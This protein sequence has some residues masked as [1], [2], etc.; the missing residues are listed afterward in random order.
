MFRFEISIG[1][2]A[3][4]HFAVAVGIFAFGFSQGVLAAD[5]PVKAPVKMLSPAYNWTG[6]YIGAH[7]G[8]AWGS[9]RWIDDPIFGGTNLGSHS[10]TGGFGGGQIGYN[11]QTGQWVFGVEASA[12]GADLKGSHLDPQA[13]DIHTRVDAFGTITGRVGY[14]WDNVLL[15]AKG[16]GAWESVKYDDFTGLGLPLNGANSSGR[17][18]WTW[19][20]GVEY[21]FMPNWSLF[22]EYNGFEFP[23]EFLSFS[24]GVAPPYG[25]TIRDR[26]GMVKAGINFRIWPR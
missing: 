1:G 20:G 8:Y 24:G 13:S 18:G 2:L 10:I 3:M 14:A 15:Y 19:G 11:W 5:M 9:S 7:G 22:V 4:R 16:G 23:N 17:W 12:S 6:F 25:Q 26:Y 21:G